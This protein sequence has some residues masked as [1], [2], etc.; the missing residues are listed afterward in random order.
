MIY[1]KNSLELKSL[2]VDQAYYFSIEAFN[3]NGISESV[4]I[5][6]AE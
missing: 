1:S 4:K 2:A 5:V 3:E 6:K